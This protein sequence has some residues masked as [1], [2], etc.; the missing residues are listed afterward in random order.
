MRWLKNH[1]LRPSPA[2]KAP[3]RAPRLGLE[4]LG[5]RLVPSVT[6]SSAVTTGGTHT[7]FAI[8][9]SVFS[10]DQVVKYTTISGSSQ[11]GSQVL[12]APFGKQFSQVSA[13]IDPKTGQAE[14]YALSLDHSL[15]RMDSGAVWHNLGGSY[16]EI[17]A[18]QDGQVVAVTSD[19]SDVRGFNKDDQPVDLGAPGGF[20]GDVAAGRGV[21]YHQDEFFATGLDGGIWV[22]NGDYVNGPYRAWREIATGTFGT[23]SATQN[24]TVFALDYLGHLFQETEFPLW[25][26]SGLSLYLWNPSNI[27]GG[28]TYTQISADVD[29]HGS[30]EVYAIGMDAFHTLSRY[31][32]GQWQ[33]L[34]WFASEVSGADGGYYFAVGGL[35]N[36]VYAYDPQINTWILLGS[37][38]K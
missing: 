29:T 6:A 19:G 11:F 36:G 22:W 25:I 13:S 18:T 26:G 14:V 23:L 3:R 15:W 27:S 17:S 20:V 7:L 28:R 32:Q 37:N 21:F 5:D 24:G 34:S 35:G 38:V 30:A 16:K 12:W 2:P 33:A 10:L 1:F 31:D 9:Q 8:S 4:R